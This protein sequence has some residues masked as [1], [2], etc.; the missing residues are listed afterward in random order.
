M[1][2]EYRVVPVDEH[3]NDLDIDCAIVTRLLHRIHVQEPDLL[4]KAALLKARRILSRIV[5][6][7][8]EQIQLA[9]PRRL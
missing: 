4:P 8:W 1:T 7:A 3:K 6:L 2:E 9:N 5:I